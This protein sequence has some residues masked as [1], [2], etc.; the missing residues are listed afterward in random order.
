M[1]STVQ[2]QVPC[3]WTLVAPSE[4]K[5]IVTVSVVGPAKLPVKTAVRLAVTKVLPPSV[6]VLVMVMVT[7]EKVPL[8]GEPALAEAGTADR[9]ARAAA[10]RH[11]TKSLRMSLLRFVVGGEVPAYLGRAA[12]HQRQGWRGM[13]VSPGS[14]LGG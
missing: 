2:A 3:P 5:T 11:G 12:G 13:A 1:P 10:I 7:G 6:R 9:I 14:F 4:W 8:A